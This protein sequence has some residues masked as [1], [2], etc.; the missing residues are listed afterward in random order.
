MRYW[1]TRH[2]NTDCRKTHIAIQTHVK[3]KVDLFQLSVHNVECKQ[4]LSSLTATLLRCS[5]AQIN[6]FY[7]L[8]HAH[9]H[10]CIS[11]HVHAHLFKLSHNVGE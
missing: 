3:H 6:D 5:C 11:V 2:L 8:A 9:V 7:T 10:V 1:C 4:A